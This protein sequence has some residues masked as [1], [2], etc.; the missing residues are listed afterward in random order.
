MEMLIYRAMLSSDRTRSQ[1]TVWA[2]GTD[3]DECQDIREGWLTVDAHKCECF[4][5]E[6]KEQFMRV[7]RA[8]PGGVKRFNSFMQSIGQSIERDYIEDYD[9][10]HVI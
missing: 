10:V 6:D 2:I 7:V 1:P 8:I 3:S 9:E 4:K 5:E